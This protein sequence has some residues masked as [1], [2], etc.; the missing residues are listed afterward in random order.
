MR[1]SHPLRN[2]ATHAALTRARAHFPHPITTPPHPPTFTST[3]APPSQVDE[4]LT[5]RRK[6]QA[7]F[8]ELS[9]PTIAGGRA[10]PSQAGALLPALLRMQAAP[11]L[12]VQLLS[13]WHTGGSLRGAAHR[14]CRHQPAPCR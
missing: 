9:F 11:L 12:R 8:V 14:S 10:P 1:K 7:G 13:A 4:E 2:T 3:S 5:R 6:E